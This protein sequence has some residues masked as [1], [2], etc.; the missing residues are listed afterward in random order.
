MVIV[1]IIT[2][3]V[4][5]LVIFLLL[6]K[7]YLLHRAAL[8]IGEG[9]EEKLAGDT[10]TLIDISS[11]DP[12]ARQLAST[13]NAQLRLLRSQ[14]LRY[15]RG[16]QELKEAVT[17]I[18]HDLR[19]PLTAICGYLELLFRQEL[20]ED[21]RRYLSLMQ[22]R[23]D[24]MKAL[25]EELFRYSVV[26]STQALPLEPVCVNAVL[27]ECVA[28]FYGALT[29]RGIQ[30]QIT[31]TGQRIERILNR[32]A[33]GRIFS[34]ILSNALKYSDG[35]LDIT[36]AD[37][38]SLTFSNSAPDL[39][40]VQVGRLFDRFFTVEAARTSGGLGLSIARTLAQQLGG[41]LTASLEGGR[42]TLT[43]QWH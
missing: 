25:T 21:S 32:E 29:A 4:L 30:P 22:N 23:V 19:T 27:E 39:N 42:L 11:R 6:G 15:Q 12:Y 34:N 31:M 2:I 43:L 28:A 7:I 14:R 1:L 3:L 26:L 10:N 40:P 35:D 8:E 18:S 17:G 24:A 38:G 33:L 5:L 37:D 41:S 9:L 13:I 36:L 16:D 20:G